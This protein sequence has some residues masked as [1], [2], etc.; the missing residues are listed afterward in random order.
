MKEIQD[1]ELMLHSEKISHR[2]LKRKLAREIVSV[3]Y[4]N[5]AASIAEQH[6]DNVIVNKGVPDDIDE[7]SINKEIG[8][9]VFLLDY[10]LVSSR[11][12][13]KRLIKQSAVKINDETVVDIHFVFKPTTEYTIKVGKRRFIKII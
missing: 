2:D 7:T 13:A 10:K 3:Y 1:L 4:D 6:F 12:E 11:G 8:L 9:V 5:S